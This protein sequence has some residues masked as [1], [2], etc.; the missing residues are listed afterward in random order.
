[1]ATH[2][3]SGEKTLP[4]GA[5]A[6]T[7]GNCD[8]R[9]SRTESTQSV[10]FEDFVMVYKSS[11]PEGDHDSGVLAAPSSAFV[12]RSAVPLPSAGC[13]KMPRS[14]SRSD[15][16]AIRLPSPVQ[17][18]KRLLPPKVRRCIDVPLPSV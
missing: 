14:P 1:Y 3:P 10:T 16:N 13:Q 9:R 4:I 6:S 11:S 17:T 5:V 8:E 7:S 15:W 12:N 2:R 18:G